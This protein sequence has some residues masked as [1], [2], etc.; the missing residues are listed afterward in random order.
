MTVT[1][2]IQWQTSKTSSRQKNRNRQAKQAAISEKI[3]AD[4]YSELKIVKNC[5]RQAL[6]TAISEKQSLVIRQTCNL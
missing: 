4:R 2:D 5:N 3:V 1:E 6:Q